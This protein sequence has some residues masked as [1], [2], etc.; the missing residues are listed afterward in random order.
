[1]SDPEKPVSPKPEPS[2]EATPRLPVGEPVDPSRTQ[3]LELPASP[4]FRSTQRLP[5]LE[6]AVDP[7]QTQKLVLPRADEPPIRV[8]RRDE[9][10]EAAGQTQKLATQTETTRK[11][12]WKVPLGLGIL[13]ALGVATYLWMPRGSAPPAPASTGAAAKALDSPES[14]PPGMQVYLEQ[15]KAGDTRAM[16][17]LGAMYYNGLNVPRDR[18]KGLYWYRMAAEKGSDAAR[19]ELSKLEGGR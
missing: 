1:M 10:L 17:M 16:R 6:P 12:G 19:S 2:P 5:L 8:Q 13:V 11:L 3:R 7:H 15:A 18:E 9:P 14:V 4:S